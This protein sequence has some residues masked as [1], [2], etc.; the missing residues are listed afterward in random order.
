MDQNLK[1]LKELS[2]KLEETESALSAFWNLAPNLFIVTLRTGE[3]YKINRICKR[4]LG[5]EPEEIIGL[6]GKSLIH[7]EDVFM[8]AA[9]RKL[10]FEEGY[11]KDFK[12]RWRHK[13]GQY[14]NLIWNSTFVHSEKYIYAIGLEVPN[15]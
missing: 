9:R 7:P 12:C 3:I 11:V 10:A 1:K 5:Y 8:A 6:F 4:I 15:E 14:V 13:D 2:V